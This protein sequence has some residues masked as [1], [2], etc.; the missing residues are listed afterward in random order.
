MSNLTPYLRRG[1][2]VEWL[3][4]AGYSRNFVRGL[5]ENGTIQPAEKLHSDQKKNYYERD[6][7]RKAVLGEK[8]P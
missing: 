5:F 8:V 6:Q 2:V 3:V 1:Q 7:I 4:G